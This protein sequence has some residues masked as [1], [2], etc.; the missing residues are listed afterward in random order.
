VLSGQMKMIIVVDDN[1]DSQD[2]IQP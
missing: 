2:T 1:F